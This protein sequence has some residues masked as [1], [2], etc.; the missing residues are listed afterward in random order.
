MGTQWW[1]KEETRALVGGLVGSG[2]VSLVETPA[3]F[4]N[5]A[6]HRERCG[7]VH[8][9]RAF[10]AAAREGKISSLLFR[11]RRL[12]IEAHEDGFEAERDTPTAVPG[13]VQ[14]EPHAVR[15]AVSPSPERS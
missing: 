4:R 3:D 13:I 1:V 10:A 11:T 14:S 7:A 9:A 5:G 6:V 15:T 2:G 12:G 8:R